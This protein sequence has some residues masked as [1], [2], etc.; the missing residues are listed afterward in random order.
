MKPLVESEEERQLRIDTHG[1]GNDV[2]Y[3]YLMEA[4]LKN[5]DASLVAGNYSGDLANELLQ[6]LIDRFAMKNQKKI[7]QNLSEFHH[8]TMNDIESGSKFVDRVKQIVT[9]IGNQDIKEL[10]TDSTIITVLKEGIKVRES[11]L[12]AVLERNNVTLSQ[13]Y[14]QINKC[15]EKNIYY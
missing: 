8:M 15:G 9:I 1:K 12:Y 10:P 13:L 11:M 3:S 7:Q 4:C 6:C 14:T 5:D 2:A